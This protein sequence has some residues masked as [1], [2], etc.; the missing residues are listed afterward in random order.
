MNFLIWHILAILSVMGCSLLIGYSIGIKHGNHK[1][2]R[3]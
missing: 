1:K 2:D 3:D